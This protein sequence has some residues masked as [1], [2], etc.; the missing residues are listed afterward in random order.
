MINEEIV[1]RAVTFELRMAKLSA[2]L[3]I[4]AFKFILNEANSRQ[5]SVR[6]YLMEQQAKGQLPL[7]DLVGK[8]TLESIPIKQR[9]LRELKKE[10][11]RHGVNFS[12][13]KNKE[14][15]DYSVFFQAKDTSVIE[16]AFKD[17]VQKAEK[18]IKMKQSTIKKIRHYQ[19]KMAKQVRKPKIKQKHQ[20]QSL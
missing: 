13:L 3:V 15:K 10:L 8:G 6:Q 18:K 20:E 11:N 9:E 5:V 17:A 12:V 14:S 16:R 4:G 19:K 1:S 7:K 2:R